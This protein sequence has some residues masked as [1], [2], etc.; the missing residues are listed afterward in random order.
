[1]QTRT[2]LN[3]QPAHWQRK[4]IQCN[5]TGI[6]GQGASQSSI[7]SREKFLV[8]YPKV[9]QNVSG[10]AWSSKVIEGL[11][12][13]EVLQNNGDKEVVDDE[14]REGKPGQNEEGPSKL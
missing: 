1:M 8:C 11:R 10:V 12:D 7:A 3:K 14:D 9:F 4:T 13:M 2:G 5:V 6:N